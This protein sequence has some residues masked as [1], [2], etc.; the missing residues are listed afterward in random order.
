MGKLNKG[1]RSDHNITPHLHLKLRRRITYEW[2]ESEVNVRRDGGTCHVGN[3][4][5]IVFKV[6]KRRMRMRRGA[7]T[8]VATA[9][10]RVLRNHSL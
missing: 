7:G 3:G 10:T 5:V 4:D 9:N 1:K 2:C 6:F 8:R